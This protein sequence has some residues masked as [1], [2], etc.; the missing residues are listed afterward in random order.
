MESW[1]D[2]VQSNVRAVIGDGFLMWYY[3]AALRDKRGWE[4]GM[5]LRTCL[6]QK[7]RFHDDC[8]D[9]DKFH[10]KQL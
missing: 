10:V 5:T 8:H 6:L 7:E 3:I 4:Y 9:E 2:F 1:G